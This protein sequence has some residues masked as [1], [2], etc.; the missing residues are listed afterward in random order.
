MV[1]EYISVRADSFIDPI[2]TLIEKATSSYELLGANEVQA[3][4]I[5]N[6]YSCSII[7][8][9]I[10]MLEGLC[11]TLWYRYGKES[12]SKF[13]ANSFIK[14][15]LKEFDHDIIDELFIIRDIIAHNH[16]WKGKIE[17]KDRTLIHSEI[18]EFYSKNFGDKKYHNNV[19]KDL[20]KT[21]KLGLNIFTTR[22]NW[23]DVKIVLQNVN[24]VIEELERK[25]NHVLIGSSEYIL[26]KEKEIKFKDLPN[27]I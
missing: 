6:G 9:D 10:V 14:N 26:F 3:S 20:M 15:N 13:K 16:L 1:R 19:D 11:T 25:F 21:K 4:P 17:T 18:P 24:T 22:I 27:Y 5:E 23:N 12:K 2:V 7:L 8:L